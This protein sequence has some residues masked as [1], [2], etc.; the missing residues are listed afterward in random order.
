VRY[1]DGRAAAGNL[2]CSAAATWACRA[3]GDQAVHVHRAA[4]ILTRAG[5]ER[6][7]RH[8]RGPDRRARP[9][10]HRAAAA[11]WGCPALTDRAEV[12]QAT[13]PHCLPVVG[14]RDYG[15]VMLKRKIVVPPEHMYPADEWRVIEARYTAEFADRIETCFSLGNGFVGIR[16][17]L[18]EGRPAL[19]PG[20][21]VNGFHETWPIMHPEGAA[22]LARTGQTMISGRTRRYSGCMSMTSH[23]S[24]RQR[25]FVNIR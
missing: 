19:T 10:R 25:A 21:F 17:S 23:C 1:R 5:H 3:G 13:L 6:R 22:A 12:G 9:E 4:A 24:C 2:A 7:Y 18:E 15:Q 14:Q 11:A 8:T 20:T 16:G